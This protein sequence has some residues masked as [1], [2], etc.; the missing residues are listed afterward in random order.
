MN[1]TSSNDRPAR[2]WQPAVVRVFAKD[3]LNVVGGTV[4]WGYL[5]HQMR[6]ALVAQKVLT[7]ALG[8]DQDHV[9]IAALECLRRDLRKAL[10]MNG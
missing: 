7:V 9:S 4:G 2:G 1:G 3:V 6:E 8:Q 5:S 10:G